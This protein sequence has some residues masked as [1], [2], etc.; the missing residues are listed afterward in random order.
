MADLNKMM[1]NLESRS[2]RLS[3]EIREFIGIYDNVF[4]E[5]NKEFQQERVA[6]GNM[7]GLE[8]FYRL[9]NTLKR[10]RDIL[11]SL[12]RGIRGMRPLNKFR[13]IEEE[14]PQSEEEAKDQPAEM[15]EYEP[16]EAEEPEEEIDG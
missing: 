1:D 5:A 6:A 11:G 2:K 10:N 3:K 8:D 16:A 4:R 13:F 12:E 9:V 7:D 15:Y 14:V